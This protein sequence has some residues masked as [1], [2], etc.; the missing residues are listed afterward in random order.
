M[1]MV[2]SAL[3]AGISQQEQQAMRACLGVY[4]QSFRPEDVV[5]DFGDGRNM[6]GI[7][8]EGAA[9]VERIDRDGNRTI[10]E[11]LEPG[12]VFGEMM[13]FKTV[14]RDSVVVRAV[15]PCRISFLRYGH[16][17]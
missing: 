6:L 11:H 14:G 4:E 1:T 9:V 5:Y 16:S 13:M 15:H 3:L 8:T 10:L 12:G 7:L 17:A 2:K